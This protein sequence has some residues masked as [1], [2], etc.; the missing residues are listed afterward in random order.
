MAAAFLDIAR[1]PVAAPLAPSPKAALAPLAVAAQPPQPLGSG[2]TSFTACGLAAGACTALVVAQRGSRRGLRAARRAAGGEAVE[3]SPEQLEAAAPAETQEQARPGLQSLVDLRAIPFLPEP[4]YRRFVRNVPGDAGFDPLGLA[5]KTPDE[6]VQ[7][8][9][10]E[11][12]HGRIAMLAGVG[13]VAPE[14][15][16]SRLADILGLPDLMAD[17]G[18]TPTLLNGGLLGEPVLLGSLALIFGSMAFAD[19]TIPRNTGLPGYY[20]W[21]PLNFGDVEFSKLARSLLRNDAEWVAEAEM[22]HGRIAM[23]AVTYMAFR[24]YITEEPIWPSF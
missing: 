23:V 8:L 3:A 14:L 21:D 4:E 7:K 19:I 18:C 22:K 6:F 13:F 15:L 11:L 10:A 17:Y 9:E 12:K 2:A 16:H 24:E 1:A 20:G 5:G